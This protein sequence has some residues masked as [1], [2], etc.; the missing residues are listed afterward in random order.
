MELEQ[1]AELEIF[2]RGKFVRLQ[3]VITRRKADQWDQELSHLT[4]WRM[5][6]MRRIE[7]I[8]NNRRAAIVIISRVEEITEWQ[9]KIEK[10]VAETLQHEEKPEWQK[11]QELKVSNINQ[12]S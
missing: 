3:G 9:V 11:A 4:E 1:T 8:V 2:A 10:R 7:A 5:D 12:S 6:L